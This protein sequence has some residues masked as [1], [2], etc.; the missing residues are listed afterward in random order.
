MHQDRKIESWDAELVISHIQQANCR[1]E[2]VELPECHRVVQQ[3]FWADL[4]SVRGS[5]DC[6]GLVEAQLFICA[7]SMSANSLLCHFC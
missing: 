6:V 3:A 7:T 1:F 2:K 4:A 5:A